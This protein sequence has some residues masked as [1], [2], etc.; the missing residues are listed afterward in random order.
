MSWGSKWPEKIETVEQILNA[1]V[2]SVIAANPNVNLELPVHIYAD[3]NNNIKIE[4]IPLEK[5]YQNKVPTHDPYTNPD[6]HI[7]YECN[8]GAILDPGTKSFAALNNHASEMG[9][10]IRWGDQAYVPYCVKCGE[11]VE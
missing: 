10:K 6:A 11:G 9:W 7:Y 8:C 3:E 1:V 5:V 2:D 4:N